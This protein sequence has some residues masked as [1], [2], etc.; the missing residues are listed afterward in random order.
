ML[1]NKEMAFCVEIRTHVIR[2]TIVRISECLS[3][4]AIEAMILE[5]LYYIFKFLSAILKINIQN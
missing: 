5:K 1:W 3:H 4:Y 2:G